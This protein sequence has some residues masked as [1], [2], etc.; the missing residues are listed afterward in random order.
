MQLDQRSIWLLLPQV[1]AQEM[2]V[3]FFL[4][5]ELVSGLARAL[6]TS[7][8]PGQIEGFSSARLGCTGAAR[9]AVLYV[10]QV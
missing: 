1:R 7:Y 5:L 8:K 9:R 6:C 2:Q 4:Q 3:L 10:N